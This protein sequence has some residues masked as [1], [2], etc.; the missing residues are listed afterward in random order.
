MELSEI[1]TPIRTETFF[2]EY[3]GKKHLVLSRFRCMDLFTFDHVESYINRYPYV[4]S[5][6]II[7]Y[8]DKGT[9]WCLDKHEKLGQPF[10]SKKEVIA[11]WRKGKTIVIPFAEYENKEMIDLCF[12]FEKYFGHGCINVYASPR[13]GSKSFNVHADSTENFLF[14]QRGNTK[15]TMYKE[16]KGEEPKTIID[17]FVLKG[18]DMLY[19]PTGQFHK[20]EADTARILCSVHFPNKR[21]QTLEKFT[22]SSNKANP[23]EKWFEPILKYDTDGYYI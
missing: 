9:R 3:W 4:R 20:V 10:L 13:A 18:G 7:D 16:F 1:L 11:L 8:D 22:I 15:W 14:H 17:E 21:N 6:Q 5:L 2:K 19:I 23:R 12:E